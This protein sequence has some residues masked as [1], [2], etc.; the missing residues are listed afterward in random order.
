MGSNVIINEDIL[1]DI[2]EVNEIIHQLLASEEYKAANL[3]ERIQIVEEFLDGIKAEQMIISYQFDLRSYRYVYRYRN[4]LL[5]ELS[6]RDK[7]E[8]IENTEDR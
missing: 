6:L 2:K 3:T 1:E 8:K 7:P 4:G 5:G